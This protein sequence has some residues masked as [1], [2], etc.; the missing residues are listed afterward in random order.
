MS[1]Q[2]RNALLGALTAVILLALFTRLPFVRDRLDWRIQALAQSVSAAFFP[3]EEAIFVP[4][5]P[6]PE[7]SA[8]VSLPPAIEATPTPRPSPTITQTIAPDEPTR[9]P[10][11]TATPLPEMVLLSGMKYFDQHGMWNY[12]G[13]ATLAMALSYWGWDGDRLD[14]GRWLKPFD[15][16]LNVMPYEMANYARQEAG[17]AAVVRNGG[18]LDL[19]KRMVAGGFPVVIEKGTMIRET[20]T[21]QITW[22]GHYN[23]V[24]GYDDA[25]QEVIV[26]DSFYSP[27]KHPLD[28]RIS[29]EQILQE[30]RGFNYLF[31]VVYPPDREAEV[32]ALLGEYADATTASQIAAERASAEIFST[33][34]ADR[35]FAWF[36]RGSSLVALQD[37]H[38]GALAYDEAFLY[39]ASLP[40]EETPKK[41]MRIVWY[42]TGPYFAYFFTGRY[43]DVIN[44][45]GQA[46]AVASRGPFLEES[47]FWR[48]RARY[49]LGDTAGALE[50]L[51]QS[52]VYHPGFEPSVQLLNDWG[53]SE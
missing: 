18:T 14:A 10:S 16:D 27:P 43:Q 8:L 35:F 52:L 44:L 12:C 39:L 17:L 34:G 48:A 32:M 42:Q 37:Y 19:L 45:A 53:Y 47:F 38:G 40:E 13:P 5:G 36:N 6:A 11:P 3:Q 24:V 30:W 21:G 22:M 49:M 7:T 26:R 50:D 46:M 15:E 31:L 2:T 1:L 20:T 28:F 33:S 29:Y 4:V 51:R 23:L 41:I 25:A 9:T